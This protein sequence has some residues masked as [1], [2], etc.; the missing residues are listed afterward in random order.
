MKASAIFRQGLYRYASHNGAD[1]GSVTILI[2]ENALLVDLP[3][4]GKALRLVLD[5][6]DK[7]IE[8][9]ER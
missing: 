9:D 7:V 2:D 6:D 5:K 8:D 3:K 1:D 4:K